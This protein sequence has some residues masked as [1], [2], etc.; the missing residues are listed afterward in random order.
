M[1]EHQYHLTGK[2]QYDAQELIILKKQD[3]C[4]LKYLYFDSLTL[5]LRQ[6]IFLTENCMRFRLQVP[7]TNNYD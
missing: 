3:N 7:P 2:A 5:L 1:S 6:R 4:E